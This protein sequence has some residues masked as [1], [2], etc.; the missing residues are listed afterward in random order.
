MSE[1]AW[2]PLG[3]AVPGAVP[4]VTALPASPVD[5]QECVLTDSLTAGTYHWH[6]Q[7]V[8]GR[9]TNKWVFVGGAPAV[10]EIL[11]AENRGNTAYG[12]LTTV[13]PSFTIPVAGDYLISLGYAAVFVSGAGTF[14][15]TLMSVSIGG[16]AAVDGDAAAAAHNNTVN[17]RAGTTRML[18][19]LGLAAATTLVAKYR[20][21]ENNVFTYSDR[22]LTVQPIAIG[23]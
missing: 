13:G 22:R 16:G 12:D 17:T 14:N 23:G 10:A 18:R 3:G 15:S 6:L 9:A 21:G 4:L 19:K 11:T 2:V 1:P 20:G 5:G 7:Y 8:A